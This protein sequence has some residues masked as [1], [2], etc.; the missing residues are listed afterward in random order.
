V[1]E[2][3]PQLVPEPQ[4]VTDPLTGSAP[5]TQRVTPSLS[6]K[7]VYVVDA[8]SLIY[9]VFHAMPEMS[10]PTGQPV[11]AV[12][13]FTRDLIELLET[14]QPD[15]LICA[16]D[17]PGDNFRHALYPPY[18]EHR[19]SMP[20]DL[21]LQIQLIFR[22]LQAMRIPV[23]SIP[24]FEADDILAT[25]AAIVEQGGGTCTLVTS[26]KDCRQLITDH[27]RL[28]HIR[29]Q[30]FTD[31]A[32][33]Q[34]VWGIRPDQVVDF[35]TLVGDQTDAIPG[36]P[37]I[38][39][40]AAQ[41]LLTKY[42]T[43]DNLLDHAH[44]VSG[45][46]RRAN[47]LAARSQALISRQLVRLRS[48]VPLE[49]DWE[50]A[51]SGQFDGPAIQKL[52]AE[53]GFR[54]LSQKLLQPKF[55]AT[56]LAGSE[57]SSN[58][59]NA[60]AFPASSSHPQTGSTATL[61]L[62]GQSLGELQPHASQPDASTLDVSP[63]G[64]WAD[65]SPA[66]VILPPTT[67]AD[68]RSHYRTITELSELQD[69]ITQWQVCSELSIDTETT[70]THPRRAQLVGL[71][72]AWAAGEACYVPLRAPPGEPRLEWDAVRELLRPILE[73]PAIAKI[74]QNLKYDLTVLRGAGVELRGLAC[75]TMVADYLLEPGERAHNLDELAR[76]YLNHETMKIDE[77]IGSGRQQRRMDEVPVA[78]I[79]EY[80]AEDA[81]VAWRL[82][83]I[84]RPR[85]A[86]LGLNPLF[87]NLEMPLVEVLSDLEYQGIAVEVPRLQE[88]GARFGEQLE[89]LE[90]DIQSLAGRPFNI[91]STQQLAQI[92]FQELKLP[93]VKKTKTGASTD[94]EVLAELAPL[95]ALPAKI[96]EYRQLAKLSSTYVEAL[97]QLVLAET[98][99]VHTSFK[100]DVAATGR[101]S[102]TEPNLQNIPIRTEAGRE[103]RRA[104][105][106]GPTGWQLL[107]ADY[108]QIE[109]RMLAHFSGDERLQQS[110]VADED[111]HTRVASE[112]YGVP[113]EGVTKE[114]R[115]SAKAINF[116]ILYGQSPFGLAKSLGITQED[117]ATY[118]AAYFARYP[119]VD[120]FLE[121]VLGGA[122]R[123]GYVTTIL[124]R[125]RKIQGVRPAHQRRDS[126]QRNLPERIAINTVIQGSAADLIKQAMI[127][128][129]RRLRAENWSA[130]M[131]LQIHDELIFEVAPASQV[132]LAQL[133]THEMTQAFP[134][135]VPLR[136]DVATG[137]TWADCDA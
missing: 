40:K 16:F 24:E 66:A 135:S 67:T 103:I 10:S 48:D 9:Q 47:L 105:H 60:A 90:R 124:G 123:S 22:L 49:I 85:L 116:G 4:L 127:N 13:G 39:P 82:A 54:H 74:G 136:V 121:K 56:H 96:L 81:D 55:L 37:L 73:N 21:R 17:H 53:F 107:A 109:L 61:T 93:I 28:Y 112:V 110:F 45:E 128:I 99:R 84:L 125:R 71:S 20:E 8:H 79:A 97:P 30:E 122:A 87:Q 83:A 118:I 44:E 126:R 7:S 15:Y 89:Q 6:G 59:V 58:S 75:D 32:A 119:G 62:A 12:H 129:H 77:L 36:V 14:R 23:Y 50:V 132:A 130:H 26:D 64:D 131:L 115:R 94:A 1:P 101:L 98:G 102:S 134:L 76:R 78:L 92:L 57:L 18:K 25:I 34:R 27:V 65:P 108:S 11:A 29:K 100:Q 69:L 19:E 31:A 86:Q 41:E 133:V 88:L 106:A 111:I 68:Y 5:T 35:Q 46:K 3:Q 43:L 137:A 91:N 95:H 72:L 104:F 63:S 38:G 120:E 51:Q 117:A 70:D 33:L 113:L 2:P 114:M 42:Q 52:C 80:A